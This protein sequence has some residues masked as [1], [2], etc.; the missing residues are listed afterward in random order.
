MELSLSGIKDKSQWL[1]K[2]YAL[3]EYDIEEV[4]NRAKRCPEWIHFGCGNLFRAFMAKAADDLLGRGVLDRGIIAAEGFDEEITDK[5]LKPHDNLSISVTLRHDGTA[6]KAVLGSIAE[7]LVMNRDTERLKEIFRSP[8][9]KLASFT[10]T[11]KGYN[12]FGINREPYPDVRRDFELGPD[13]AESYIGRITALLYERFRSGGEPIAMVSMD[14]CS[15]N[16]D[17]LRGAVCAFA[18]EWEKNGFTDEGFCEYLTDSERVSFPHTMIDKITPRPDPDIQK[19]LEDDGVQGANIILTAKGTYT[20][21]FVNA[22]EFGCL[23][24]EDIFP[25]GRPELQKSG[26]IFTDRETVAKAERMKVCT[27]LNP[28]HTALAVFGCLLGYTKI[29]EEMKDPCLKALVRGIGCDEGLPAAADPGIIKPKEFLD[30]VIDMRLPN[31]FMPDSPQRIATDTSQKL[32]VRFGETIKT[33]MK[34]DDLD[35]NDLSLIPLVFAG[36]IRYLTG[37]DDTGTDFVPSP[38]PLM[39]RLEEYAKNIHLGEAVDRGALM[40]L[41]EDEEVFGVNLREAELADK[42]LDLLDRMNA[43]PGAVRQT[44]EAMIERKAPVV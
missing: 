12:I 18:G 4:S 36:W 2:G 32:A 14:N 31:P 11:E 1:S 29:S 17:R 40:P 44:L 41:L 33:Y 10:V 8:S 25:G 7:T 23:V 28:L 39:P 30:S 15:K 34:S 26:I 19:L 3:P 27:C 16:G 42:V 6:D 9:L 35:V 20:A 38:D 43:E 21:S 13:A 5:V 24:I 37:V 22:E